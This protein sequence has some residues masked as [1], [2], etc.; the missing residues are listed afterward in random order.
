MLIYIVA[1]SE[2]NTVR[3]ELRESNILEDIQGECGTSKVQYAVKC[4][5]IHRVGSLKINFVFCSGKMGDLDKR[6][7]SGR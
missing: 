7:I 3:E 4:C 2:A 6:S 5:L 1:G